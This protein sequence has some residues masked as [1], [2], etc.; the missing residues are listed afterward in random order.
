M[1]RRYGNILGHM[2]VNPR[3][4]GLSYPKDSSIALTAFADADHA[5]CQD[6]R[7]STSGSMQFLGD[8]LVS[9]SSKRLKSVAIFSTEAEYIALSIAFIPDPEEEPIPKQAPA[10][11]VGFAPQ[12]IGG[13]I[14]Y[15]NNGWLEEDDEKDP[16]EG[17]DEDPEEDEVDEDDEEDPEEDDDVDPDEDEVESPSSRALLDGNSVVFAA[18]PKPSDLMTI[19]SI[20][21]KLEKQMFERLV[22]GL[23]N[24]INELKLQCSRAKRLSQWEVWVRPCIPERLRFQEEPLIPLA[25]APRADDLYVMARDAAMAA[26]EEDD[27]DV[28][29]AKDPQPSESRGSPRD[30]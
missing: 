19:H 25:F 9:W 26:Q 1:G 17:D 16:E 12:W 23:S 21:T 5:G 22:E 14:P 6:T 8:R 10:A 11:L 20:T 28:V 18:G 4:G 30:L 27:D 3:T 24:Q 13:Q 29:A 15:N 2:A 7:R